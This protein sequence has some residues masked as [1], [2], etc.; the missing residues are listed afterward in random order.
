MKSKLAALF[1]TIAGFTTVGL[2]VCGTGCGANKTEIVITSP[3]GEVV[4]YVEQAQRYLLQVAGDNV[5]FYC[6]GTGSLP[7]PQVPIV[8]EWTSLPN[9]AYYRVEYATNPDFENALMET[10]QLQ[11]RVELYNLYKGSEYYL[12]VTAYNKKGKTLSVANGTFSTTDLGPRV[13]NVDG[14]H[15]VRD[16]G[17][18]TTATGKRTV[19]GLL[20]RG[21]TLTPA[22]V[23]DSNLTD[24]GKAYMRSVLGIKTDADLRG[25]QEAKNEQS[26]IPDAK[27]YNFGL[28]GYADM[29]IP[30]VK[31][32]FSVLADKDNYPIYVHCTGGADRTGTIVFLINA[33]L[34][35]DEKSLIQDYEFTSFSLYAM[36]NSKQGPYAKMFQEFLQTVKSYEGETLQEQTKNCLLSLGVTAEEIESIQAIMFGEK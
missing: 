31:E 3:K 36:R 11:T 25:V 29:L 1:C 16:V 12:R 18:Y 20:F 17:G 28:N 26:P 15:N 23:Y 10:T 9:A 5:A 35:V 19:Q 32:V 22:D 30:K 27:L 33:L 34:G 4:P 13:M 24:D 7:N 21:G 14:I 8:V 6:D 2:S